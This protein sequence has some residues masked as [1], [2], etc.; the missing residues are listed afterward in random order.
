MADT[1]ALE[2]SRKLT[3]FFDI[4]DKTPN[5]V[6]YG[7]AEINYAFNEG[8]IKDFMIIDGLLRSHDFKKRSKFENL[9]KRMKEEGI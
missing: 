8:A 9:I 6:V 2:E 3:E 5:K 7:E 4:F 1:K